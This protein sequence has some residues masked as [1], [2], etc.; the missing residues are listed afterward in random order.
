MA[1]I[2]YTSTDQVRSI[3]GCTVEDI[4][5]ATITGRDPVTELTADLY[6]WLPT[7]ATIASEGSAQTP[8]A[9]QS[10]KYNLLK[11]YSAYYVASLVM[12]AILTIIP[13]KISDG[14]NIMGRYENKQELVTMQGKAYDKAM[15]FKAAL[16]EYAGTTVTPMAMFKGVGS[17][18]DPVT[19]T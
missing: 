4:D 10:H 16:L 5:D 12:E 14:K 3:M 6:T 7:H 9:L 13:A 2:L 17:S 19:N 1:A 8:T 15:K 18:Y 11:L